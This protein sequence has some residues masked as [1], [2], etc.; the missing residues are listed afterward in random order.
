MSII[1]HISNGVLFWTFFSMCQVSK[2]S[3]NLD[4]AS[5]KELSSLI[6]NT[7]TL[8][9]V[10]IVMGT[11]SRSAQTKSLVVT[12]ISTYISTN[13]CIYCKASSQL[14]T[15]AVLAWACNKKVKITDLMQFLPDKVNSRLLQV[16]HQ[17]RLETNSL[18][19][20]TRPFFSGANSPSWHM[21]QLTPVI[22]GGHWHWWLIEMS[23]GRAALLAIHVA[24]PA[25]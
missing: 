9:V 19:W 22:L 17:S 18:G 11:I 12:S 1:S 6:I 23:V 2:C 20:S 13:T 25:Q 21:S 4:K 3:I 24:S 7:Y 15:V 8:G 14:V 10:F 5:F 16:N